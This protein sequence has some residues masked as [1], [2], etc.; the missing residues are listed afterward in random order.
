MKCSSYEFA[1][2]VNYFNSELQRLRKKIKLYS[3]EEI[4]KF[5]GSNFTLEI[6]ENIDTF[7]TKFERVVS[8]QENFDFESENVKKLLNLQ[9][10]A[11]SKF[12]E[13]NKLCDSIHSSKNGS[14][15]NA[16][17]Y[18][19]FSNWFNEAYIVFRDIYFLILDHIEIKE[20][21]KNKDEYIKIIEKAKNKEEEMD[22]IIFSLNAK[23]KDLVTKLEQIVTDHNISDIKLFYQTNISRT[24]KEKRLYGILFYSFSALF[25]VLFILLFAFVEKFY[26]NEN[27]YII[28]V[29]SCISFSFIGF[30]TFIIH[31]FRKRFNVAKNILDE[32]YQKEVVVDTY[33]S[34]LSRISDFDDETKKKYHDK[35]IQNIIDTLLLIKSH[36]YMSKMLNQDD[37]TILTKLIE[38]FTAAI[39]KTQ[40]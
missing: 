23:S 19:Q 27:T 33:S 15:D 16:F 39:K 30:F 5:K 28:I 32:L 9:K 31:D 3:D 25:A 22:R 12:D 4:V 1:H 2:T 11:P 20:I 24:L 7:L 26:S 37:S 40:S 14:I 35:I 17:F 13:F 8:E 38:E 6:D 10:E 29:R 34:L 18:V 36:G 21:I